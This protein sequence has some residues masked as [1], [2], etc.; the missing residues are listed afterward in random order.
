MGEIYSCSGWPNVANRTNLG[1]LLRVSAARLIRT[2]PARNGRSG[3]LR[4]SQERPRKSAVAPTSVA[5][6]RPPHCDTGEWT[7]TWRR[8]TTTDRL[9]RCFVS[10]MLQS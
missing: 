7:A 4:S 5:Q 10:S 1:R 2:A 9:N 6:G 8:T 3:D